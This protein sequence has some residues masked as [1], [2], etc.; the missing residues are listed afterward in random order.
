MNS[1]ASSSAIGAGGAI[2]EE[3]N[4]AIC[5]GSPVPPGLRE[6]VFNQ[7]SRSRASIRLASASMT[8]RR[9]ATMVVVAIAAV[10]I[11]GAGLLWCCGQ[12][13][14]RYGLS[15]NPERATENSKF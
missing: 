6:K 4:E 8:K 15:S 7:L 2:T 13:R 10:V 3:L 9:G 1:S 11:A 12:S 5:T 14:A